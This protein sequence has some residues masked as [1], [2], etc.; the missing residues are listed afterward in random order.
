MWHLKTSSEVERQ[1]WITTLELARAG[2]PNLDGGSGQDNTDS[3]S[4]EDDGEQGPDLRV[5]Q[6]KLV[7][8]QTCHDLIKKHQSSLQRVINDLGEASLEYSKLKWRFPR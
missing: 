5:L 6:S 2:K 7:D 3:D 1:K 4:D 8:L